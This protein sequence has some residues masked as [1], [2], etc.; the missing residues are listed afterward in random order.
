MGKHLHWVMMRGWWGQEGCRLPWSR[1][2]FDSDSPCI[3]GPFS[4]KE[5]TRADCRAFQ[6]RILSEE[7][8]VHVGNCATFLEPARKQNC[9]FLCSQRAKSSPIVILRRQIFDIIYKREI[10][11]NL[12]FVTSQK[13][14]VC[15]T[16]HLLSWQ[17]RAL[18]EPHNLSA[19]QPTCLLSI[20][21]C[22]KPDTFPGDFSM[23]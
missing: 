14:Y 23:L 1:E 9:H 22:D 6:Q 17:E 15:L 18:E 13:D 19:D 2:S 8:N 4:D 3:F 5:G 21:S 7:A 16:C 10:L 20:H 11:E 12:H